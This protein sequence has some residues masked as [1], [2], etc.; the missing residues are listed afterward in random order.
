[1]NSISDIFS[2]EK[3]LLVNVYREE[4]I[5]ASFV[6]YGNY[7]DYIWLADADITKLQL[8]NLPHVLSYL[9]HTGSN[10]E[11]SFTNNVINKA[12]IVIRQRDGGYKEPV[13]RVVRHSCNGHKC[14]ND[15]EN[16]LSAQL[17]CENEKNDSFR[18]TLSKK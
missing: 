11:L 14:L 1:M 4:H 6:T 12:E 13:H 9:Q 8:E 3:V 10:L 16:I 18:K 2:K 5:C 17:N 7:G 15:L